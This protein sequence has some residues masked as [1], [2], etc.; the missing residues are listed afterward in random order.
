VTY[1]AVG[2]RKCILFLTPQLP[3]PP[4]QGTAI[5]NYNLIAQVAKWHEV[6]L[7]SFA[8]DKQTRNDLGPLRDWCRGVRTVTAPRR[9]RWSRLRTVLASPYPDLHHRLFSS[10]FHDVLAD[11]L[12]QVRPQVVEIEGLE[13]A[14]FGLRAQQIATDAPP[15]WVFDA[16]NAEY[17]LQQRVFETDVRRPRR[18]LGALYSW[19]Q[20]RKLR[21][22]EAG[23]CQRADRVV[24]CSAADASA[25]KRLVPGLQVVV[26]PNGVDISLYQPA[27]VATAALGDQ[28]LVFTGKMDFRPNVD[29]VLWFCSRVWP[30]VQQAEPQ[31]QFYIVGRDPH[32]RLGPLANMPG[33]T[34]TGFVDDIRPYIAAASVYVVPLLT[35]GGTRLKVLEAMAMGKALVSTT[36]GCEG[37]DAQPGRDLVLADEAD[38]FASQVVALLRDAPRREA[39]GRAARA[40]VERNFDWPIVTAPLEQVYER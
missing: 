39:L 29:A 11:V 16:H 37:I 2:E 22:Y 38:E 23:V 7:L 5:R 30:L 3:Y 4:Q 18:W 31:A 10:G 24:A 27:G 20:W 14:Q 25:L 17:V 36:L 13:M 8:T 34:L 28:A 19:L 33:V 32:P 35:G 15:L 26:V 40:F 1:E 6:H 9:S 21:S 12:E